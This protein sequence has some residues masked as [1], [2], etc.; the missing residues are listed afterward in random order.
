MEKCNL[1]SKQSLSNEFLEHN[2]SGHLLF[3]VFPVA[4]SP[5]SD[6]STTHP[7]SSE[8]V[9][10]LNSKPVVLLGPPL[11]HPTARAQGWTCD[12]GLA[13][14]SGPLTPSPALNSHNDGSMG[15]MTKV[16]PITVP[17]GHFDVVKHEERPFPSSGGC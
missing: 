5:S 11:H 12:P 15:S 8:E 16:W 1:S 2:C 4:F 14:H 9:C 13:N 3:L 6:N 17:P 7:S 10:L